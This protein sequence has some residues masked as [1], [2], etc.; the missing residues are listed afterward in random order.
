MGESKGWLRRTVEADPVL[1]RGALVSVLG[2]GATIAN[3]QFAEGQVESVVTGVISILAMVSALWSRGKVIPESK[4]VTYMPSPSKNPG[5]VVP[6][7]GNEAAV[8]MRGG[9]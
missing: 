1:V 4:V 7:K 2:L 8:Y 5:L 3:H 6:G 9:E